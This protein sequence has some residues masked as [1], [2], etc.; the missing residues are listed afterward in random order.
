MCVDFTDP[1]KACLNNSFHL[2]KIDKLVDPTVD[3]EFLS[4]LDINLGYHQ[5]PM[6]LKDEEKTSFI[7][8]ERT[9]CYKAMLFSL[10]N[11]R[12]TYQ[13]MVNK[14]F[15]HQTERNMEAYVD[16]MLVKIMTSN[17]I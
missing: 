15:K 8:E 7:I 11:T 9:F 10:K 12:I 6:Y 4:S 14:L 5:I 2:Q 17:N 16:D 3:F 13:Q 1:N